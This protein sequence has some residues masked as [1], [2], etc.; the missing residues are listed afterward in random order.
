MKTIQDIIGSKPLF[1][2]SFADLTQEEIFDYFD[3]DKE[4]RKKWTILYANYNTP[5]YEGYAFVL[6]TDGADLYEVHGS[7]CSCYGL[8]NQWGPEKVVLEE[9]KKRPVADR[10]DGYGSE[11]PGFIE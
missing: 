7:H 4:E 10:Y 6:T 11:F 3:L 5:P 2:D 8:E 1:T 9:L